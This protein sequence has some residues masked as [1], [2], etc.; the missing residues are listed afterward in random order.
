MT[1]QHGYSEK[2]EEKWR[3]CVDLTNLHN[4]FKI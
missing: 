4:L 1:G 2:N 3:I